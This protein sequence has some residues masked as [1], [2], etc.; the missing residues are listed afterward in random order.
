MSGI[1]VL[2]PN[3]GMNITKLMNACS[4]L[5]F[6]VRPICGVHFASQIQTII[7]ED[8]MVNAEM[9]KNMSKRFMD[10][11]FRLSAKG[12]LGSA[13]MH[14]IAFWNT[15]RMRTKLFSMEKQLDLLPKQDTMHYMV[16]LLPI[17]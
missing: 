8:S 12:V 1:Q 3:A 16:D 10:N 4:S 5:M 6:P 15:Q 2:S 11:S 17:Q 13:M 14:W 7:V 9:L